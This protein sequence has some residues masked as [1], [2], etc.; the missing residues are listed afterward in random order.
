MK[1]SKIKI[2]NFRLLKSLELDL[3]KELSLVIGKNNCGKTSLLSILD[4]FIGSRSGL[5]V[6]SLDDFNIEFLKGMINI[7]EAEEYEES[8]TY[9]GISLMLFIK[10]DEEDDLSNISKLMLDL[11]PNHRIIV[12]KFEYKLIQEN[13]RKMRKDYS[14]FKVKQNIK[15]YESENIGSI[16]LRNNYKKYFQ[17]SKKSIGYNT[18]SSTEIESEYIDLLKEKIQIENVISF[19]MISAKRNVSNIDSD[20]TLSILSSNYYKKKEEKDQESE[21][22][23]EFKDILSRTDKHLNEVYN[24][25]FEKIIEKVGRFGGIKKGDSIIKIVSTLQHKELLKDNTTV[26]YDHNGE[27]SL[28][29]NYN[30]LGYLNLISMIFEIELILSEFRR[31]NKSNEKPAN[32]NLLFIE[33]PEAHTHPQMQYIFIKNIKDILN[34]ASKGEDGEKFTLQTIITTHSCHITA[35]SDFNDIK[36]F[37]KTNQNQ[38]VA[39]NLKDLEKEYE[40]DGQISN[41]KFLKQYLILHRAELFFADKAIFIEGDTE[42]LLLPAMMKKI[43]Q[44]NEENPL[45]SQNI[46]VIEVGAYS[47]V[48]EKFIA[49][50]GIKS[51]I[52][53]DIDSAKKKVEIKESGEE[54]ISNI[55]CRVT[56]KGAYTTTNASL[57]Y[58]INYNNYISSPYYKTEV[59]STTENILSESD[60]E[61]DILDFYINLHYNERILL[62]NPETKKWI[63]SKDGNLLIIYQTS[64]LNTLNVAYHARSFEDSF[65]HINKQFILDNKENFKSLVNIKHFEDKEKD[66]YFLAESCVDKKPSFAMEILLNS[67]ESS[68]NKKYCNWDIPGYIKEGLLWLKNN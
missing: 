43:D 44:E 16:F 42:R 58:F 38:V 51:L 68:D 61:V 33:E 22:I 52:I 13:L 48:F 66:S 19:K 3:E 8:S 65:F 30:G 39:K 64:E 21:K 31:E 29:E 63:P 2:E 60:E 18:E 1:I 47:H 28:P 4:K 50:I 23:Q 49:F 41:F 45:L 20:K 34:S 37:Y 59:A 12:L 25:L 11:D 14:E 32:I 17:L 36:Y 46:S 27:H 53:T 56:D 6:I 55:K 35:E 62:K 15:N 10:Y 26:M 24:N 67:K 54:K 7:L 40:K 5:N 9:L 57:K